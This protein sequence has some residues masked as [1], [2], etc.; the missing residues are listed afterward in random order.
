MSLFWQ[1]L[2]TKI[3]PQTVSPGYRIYQT[4]KSQQSVSLLGPTN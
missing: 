4:K 2:L 1:V 3:N